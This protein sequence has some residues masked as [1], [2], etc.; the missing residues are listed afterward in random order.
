MG[1]G[2]KG[3]MGAATEARAHSPEEVRQVQQ[4][5]KQAGYDPGQIDGVYG[6]RTLRALRKFQRDRDITVTGRLDDQTMQGLMS[7]GG[8][9]EE[10]GS[11]GS[12]QDASG[13]GSRPG[14]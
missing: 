11:T 13:G 2:T 12:L 6:P 7:G 4:Q 1:N 10:R 14:S 9:H 8:P 3:R 5:L